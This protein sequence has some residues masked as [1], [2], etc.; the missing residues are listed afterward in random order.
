MTKVRGAVILF[1]LLFLMLEIIIIAPREIGVSSK[2]GS[3]LTPNEEDQAQQVMRGVHLVEA[4]PDRKDW[5]LWAD[6]AFTVSDGKKWKLLNVKVR[7][8]GEKQSFYIVTGDTG[9]VE[10]ETKNVTIAGKVQMQSSN[11]YRFL[12]DT[13]SY[14]ASERT[15]MT[16]DEV[17]M[18]GGEKRGEHLTELTGRGLIASM[19]TNEILIKSHVRSKK[20]LENKEVVFIE[21]ET[22]QF[23][24]A[25]KF[26]AYLGDVAIDYKG[27]RIT[28]PSARFDY[29]PNLKSVTSLFIEGGAR[30]TDFSKWATARQIQMLFQENKFILKGAPRVVQDNDELVGEQITFIDGGK[31]IVVDRAKAEFQNRPGE[32]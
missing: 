3:A 23:S 12:T 8:F 24:A 28:G 15:I 5:E 20:E 25:H 16:P 26:A 19:A 4:K 27:S 1:M 9:E 6:E 13:M 2:P 7:F 31:E 30:I 10:I 29:D 32:L 21:S 11:G 17:K 18:R 22:A 14:N